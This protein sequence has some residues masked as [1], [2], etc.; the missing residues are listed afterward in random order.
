MWTVAVADPL[1]ARSVFL[2]DN[3]RFLTLATHGPGGPWAATVNYVPLRSPLRLLWY[4]S[5][6]ARHSTDLGAHPKA[7]ASLFLTGLP[8][9]GLDGAQL[10]GTCQE[11]AA[12]DVA[13]YHRHYYET[14]F[15]DEVVRAEWLLP[16]TEFVADGPRRF[17]LMTVE[18]WWLLDIDRWLRDKHDQ[19]VEVLVEDLQQGRW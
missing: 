3:A 9:F 13:E 17:Y 10:S 8:G 6:R 16:T 2:L 7:A 18:R 15:P 12:D 11:V 4:S 19:R 5:R 1:V 14:N